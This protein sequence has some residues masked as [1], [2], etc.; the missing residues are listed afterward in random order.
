VY[1]ARQG[2]H[3]QV[4]AAGEKN[5]SHAKFLHKVKFLVCIVMTDYL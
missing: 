2:R 5:F 4:S 1:F 3:P